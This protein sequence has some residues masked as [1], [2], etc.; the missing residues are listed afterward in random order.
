MS[1]LKSINLQHPSSASPNIVL[2]SSGNATMAGSM[3]MATPFAMRNK[4]I[5]GAME[6]DQR[7][8]G[9][10]VANSGGYSVDRWADNYA[11]SGRYSAQRSTVA[12]NGFVNSLL[13]TVTTAV[14]AAATD[15]YQ[16]FQPVEGTNAA[17]LGFGTS[18]A[19]TITVSFW[20]RSSIA[21][22]YGFFLYNT[23]GTRSIT[24][25]YTINATNTWEFKTITLPGDTAG[26]YLTN[27]GQA[28]VVGFDLGSGSNQNT[29]T[30]G[31]WQSGVYRRTS[32]CV[33]FMA[34]NGA[35]FYLTGVQLEVGSVATPFERRLY[36]QE[37]A[38]CQRYFNKTANTIGCGGVALPGVSI[39]YALYYN[40]PV[41]MR[42]TATIST[43][44]VPYNDTTNMPNPTFA[45]SSPDGV[46]FRFNTFSGVTG[47][48]LASAF[49][50]AGITFSAEL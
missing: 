9:A 6:I 36:P 44:G 18:W 47:A 12:P 2:D 3:A 22:T 15:V 35:T 43:A 14:T 29:S 1:T 39:S 41:S 17:D 26:T 28:F 46:S 45:D 11:G 23:D 7:N 16:I 50:Y 37:L 30:L 32:G 4:I 33:N 10:A 49:W 21:G 13:H 27:N 5:N 31:S 48:S 8:A 20:V 42:T 38:M 34:T 25:T 24:Q 19:K 40:Y